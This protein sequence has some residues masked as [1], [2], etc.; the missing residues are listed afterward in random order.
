MNGSQWEKQS[1]EC[2][3]YYRYYVLIG[4]TGKNGYQITQCDAPGVAVELAEARSVSVRAKQP[5]MRTG[6]NNPL[7][8]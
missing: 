2:N 4:G 1:P 6:Q 3:D 8:K 7:R 5:V